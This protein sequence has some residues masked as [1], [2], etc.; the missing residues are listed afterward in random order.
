M[1]TL[2][3]V[4]VETGGTEAQKHALLEIAAAFVHIPSGKLL[5]SFSFLVN[6]P[7]REYCA[8]EIHGISRELLT[9]GIGLE[10][11]LS[12]A[13][14]HIGSAD[15]AVAYN[16][17]FDAAWLP[18]VKLYDAFD[19]PWPRVSGQGRSLTAVA[20]AHGIGVTSAHRAI[21]DVLVLQQILER[22]VELGS[23][24]EAMCKHVMRPKCGVVA[25]TSYDERD[26]T[27]QHGFRWYP[28]AKQW[29]RSMFRDD[30]A[31]LPFKVKEL[32]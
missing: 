27:K 19:F 11:A 21:W 29:R 23:S 17:A 31:T 22:C 24:V 8:E 13:R 4:D 3:I 20:L 16:S 2:A 12:Q 14:G 30:I 9:E 10:P 26:L 25:L 15:I 28:E 6:D 1:K 7:S 18:D 32:P 5:N